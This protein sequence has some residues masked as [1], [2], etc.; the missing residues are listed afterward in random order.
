MQTRKP[1]GVFITAIGEDEAGELYVVAKSALDPGLDP[2][3]GLP[4]GMIPKVVPEPM[5]IG[6]CVPGA[7][8]LLRRRRKAST[9]GTLCLANG[10]QRAAGLDFCDYSLRC[11]AA[12]VL[13][14]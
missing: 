14:E 1:I 11:E 5:A 10:S 3:T 9:A 4:G 7:A 2:N 13:F 8:L 12:D 6:L